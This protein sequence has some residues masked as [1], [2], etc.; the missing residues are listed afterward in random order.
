[1]AVTAKE[2]AKEL[3]ISAAA[4]SMALNGKPGVSAATRRRV[5]ELAEARG[6]DM[7]KTAAERPQNEVGTIALVVYRKHG[8]VLTDTPFFFEV[9][10]GIETACA[11]AHY[12]LNVQ[13]LNADTPIEAQF[14]RLPYCG[15]MILLATEMKKGDFAPFAKLKLPLVVLDTYYENLPYD[16]VLINNFQGAFTAADYIMRKTHAQ[17]GYLR[18]SYPIGNFDERADGFFKAVRENGYSASRSQ[19]LSLAPSMDGAYHD[20][21]HLLEQGEIPARCYFADNDLIAAGAMKALKE[22]G[23]LI[24]QQVAVIGFDDMPV[25]SYTEPTLSTVQVPKQYM[26]QQAVLRLLHVMQTGDRCRVK[27]EVNTRLVKRGSV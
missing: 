17:A 3:G 13:Y 4:V 5:L 19:V 23:Y 21:K 20:M 24:P 10:S 8:A 26:G 11:E 27:L 7:T 6:Y 22:L 1:M 9:I 25:C 12:S 16:C 15:G 18:S 14:R 2:L